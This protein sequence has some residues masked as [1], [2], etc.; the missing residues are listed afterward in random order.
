MCC[1]LAVD[2]E[3]ENEDE[4]GKHSVVDAKD[5]DDIYDEIYIRGLNDG[6]I[7]N[8]AGEASSR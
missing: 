2:A 3:N 1:A 8:S 6:S 4:A 7:Y 5:Q